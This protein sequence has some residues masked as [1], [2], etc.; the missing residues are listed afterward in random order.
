[1]L[2]DEVRLS[3]AGAAS[4]ESQMVAGFRR[5][6]QQLLADDRSSPSLP[7][8]EGCQLPFV[9][10]LEK[11]ILDCGVSQPRLLEVGAGSATVS[12]LL[13]R[14]LRGTF[15]ALDILPEAVAVAGKAFDP[16]QVATMQLL[17]ADIH[18]APFPNCAFDIVFSQGLIEHFTDPEGVFLAQAQLVKKGGQLVINVPQTYNL[19]TLYKHWRMR[20]GNWP[21]GWEREYS[22]RDLIALGQRLGFVA[23]AVDGYGSFAGQ[24]TTRLFR[25]ILSPTALASL[26]QF[27]DRADRWLGGE[28]R[29]WLSP[30]LVVCF[31]KSLSS[32]NQ[33]KV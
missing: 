11:S 13:A 28:L 20:R 6:W 29:S 27:F 17:V 7:W 25:S 19:F 12:R 16:K 31:R 23:C 33:D 1:M 26:S 9:S 3:A 5:Y 8:T 30:Q 21:P 15:Y 22:P 18:N 32:C 10:M 24:V 2:T 14:K 4:H